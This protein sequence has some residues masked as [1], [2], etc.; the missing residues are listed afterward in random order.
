[1][2][3]KKKNQQI[4]LYVTGLRVT[5]EVI[6]PYSVLPT[7]IQALCSELKVSIRVFER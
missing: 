5:S 7:D 2:K 6:D 3:K 1:M 4:W